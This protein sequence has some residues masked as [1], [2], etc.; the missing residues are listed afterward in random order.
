MS[1]LAVIWRSADLLLAINAQSVVEV[2]PPVSCRPALGTPSWVRGL[3]SYR[4]TLIPLVDAASLLG[5]ER[6]PDRMSN[7]VIVVGG[8]THSE[9][10]LIGLWVESVLEIDH[11]DFAAAGMH[12]GFSTQAGRFLG[13]V[14]PTR[15]G[16]VQVV[17]PQELFTA[18]QAIVLRDPR[19][20]V[21]P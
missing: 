2:L 19:A 16:Q 21:A 4:G 7:R 12:A 20:E 5:T 14:M 15:W 10:S 18:E 13:P 9:A 6:R 17:N 11:I 1:T 8:G 3:F